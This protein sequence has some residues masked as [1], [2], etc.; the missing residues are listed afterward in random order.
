MDHA[1]IVV[2]RLETWNKMIFGLEQSPITLT[3]MIAH[4]HGN[5]RYAQY[6]NGLWF[7][8]P[9]FTIGS[10]LCLFCTLEISLILESKLLLEEPPQNSFFARLLQGKLCCV[11]KLCTLKQIVGAKLLSRNLLL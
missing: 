1:K 9:N 4:G 5:E 7:N 8:D 3:C 10:L 11:H 6:S 2:P